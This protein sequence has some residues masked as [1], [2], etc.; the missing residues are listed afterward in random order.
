MRLR[1]APGPVFDPPPLELRRWRTGAGVY[2]TREAWLAARRA[3]ERRHGQTIVEWWAGVEREARA[4]V[5]FLE[6]FTY[7]PDRD[8]DAPEGWDPDRDEW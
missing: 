3:W 8:E 7:K 2:A 6:M 5:R 1:E 4:E